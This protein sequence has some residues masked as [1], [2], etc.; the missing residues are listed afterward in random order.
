VRSRRLAVACVALW[1]AG[2]GGDDGG[3]G[4]AFLDIFKQDPDSTPTEIGDADSLR[5]D[6]ETLFGGPDEDPQEPD[7]VL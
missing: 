7:D 5:D 1:L 4:N 6:I 2:C 3:D